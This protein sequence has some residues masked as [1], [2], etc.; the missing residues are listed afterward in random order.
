MIKM[1]KTNLD[2]TYT[3]IL[4]ENTT[5]IEEI[6]ERQHQPE[7]KTR[8]YV[9][10]K[11]ITPLLKS[12]KLDRVRRGLYTAIDPITNQPIAD[13][14]IVASKLRNLYY[15]G[16]YTALTLFGSAYSTRTQAHICIPPKNRF[17]EFIYNSI[18]YT[19]LYN[20]DTKTNIKTI[21]YRGHKVRVCGK[22]RLL[23]ELIE[24]PSYVGGW[25]Q[26]LKSLE[27]LGGVEYEKIPRILEKKNIQKLTRKTGYILEL[28]RDHSIYHRSLPEEVTQKI[29]DMVTGQPE[30]MEKNRKGPLNTKW[31]LYIHTGFNNYLRGI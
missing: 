4:Q 11:I 29:Q 20:R 9:Y 23:V 6:T 18:T 17:R 15:L 21:N 24:N 5:T 14:V 10:D 1:S 25:E 16:Y 31:M 12:G 8:K 19:P 2:G 27:T 3:W 26:S 7:K 30:Y 13:P 22:E 28:L